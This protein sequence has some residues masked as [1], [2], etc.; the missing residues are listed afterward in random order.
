MSWNRTT[1]RKAVGTFKR[2]CSVIKRIP[3][4]RVATYGQVALLAGL[5]NHARQ[6]GY[7]LNALPEESH[8]P[9]HRII[10]SQG[11]ISSRSEPGCEEIQQRLLEE[12]G[13]LFDSSGKVSLE[14]FQW[15]PRIRRRQD[16]IR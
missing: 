5:P 12:E 2:I 15:D 10:N 13:I 1:E 11:R 16:N 9:W 7:A 3:K 6:V 8:L 14:K 4:G